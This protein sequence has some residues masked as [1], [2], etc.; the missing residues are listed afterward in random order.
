MDRGARQA[1]AHR[2]A[3]R[4]KRLKR[5]NMHV[6]YEA[7]LKKATVG[8]HVTTQNMK[9]KKLPGIL[10]YSPNLNLRFGLTACAL[11]KMRQAPL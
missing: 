11:Q 5:L 1:A 10:T 9:K 4:R 3:K 2:V 8:R 7:D 6:F